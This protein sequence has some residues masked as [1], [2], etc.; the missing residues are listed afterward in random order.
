VRE[1]GYLLMERK[2]GSGFLAE[3]GKGRDIQISE[4]FPYTSLLVANGD[5]SRSLGFSEGGKC[6]TS[7]G[8][9]EGSRRAGSG[10]YSST[11]LPTSRAGKH[12]RGREG[13]G[14]EDKGKEVGKFIHV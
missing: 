11:S 4:S 9:G 10:I 1:D 6:L 2:G 14:R 12:A 5:R 7:V 8:G 3:E 13:I